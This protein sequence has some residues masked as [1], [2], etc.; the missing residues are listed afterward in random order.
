MDKVISIWFLYASN[1]YQDFTP[2]EL[3]LLIYKSQ[4]LCKYFK[5]KRKIWKS[6]T[7]KAYLTI[8][9]IIYKYSKVIIKMK[10]YE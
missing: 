2:L 8:K 9:Y 6:E 7:R 3:V 10:T 4:S 5:G 1:K